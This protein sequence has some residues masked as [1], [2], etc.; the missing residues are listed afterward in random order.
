M[1][2]KRLALA[3]VMTFLMLLSIALGDGGQSAFAQ[4]G[5]DPP[6][7]RALVAVAEVVVAELAAVVVVVAA[8][9]VV[10]LAVVAVV[11]VMGMATPTRPNLT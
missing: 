10:G 5:G 4:A 7:A 8:V 11:A 6:Q 3:L 2:L 9:P 1:Q